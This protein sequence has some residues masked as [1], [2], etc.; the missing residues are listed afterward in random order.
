[1]LAIYCRTSKERD[2][3]S[4]TISQQRTAG[5]DFAENHK[6]EYEIYEDEGKS[7]FKISDDDR[8]PFNNRPAFTNLINDI[9]NKKIDKVWVWEH[10]RLSRN[11]FASSFIFNIF[12]RFNIKLFENQKELDLDDPQF[13]FQRQILDAVAEYERQLIIA[14]TNRGKRKQDEQGR[15]VHRELYGYE[16]DGKDDK[17]HTVWKV[18]QGEI[19]TYKYA[20]KRFNEGVSLRKIVAEVYNIN[21]IEKRMFASFACTIGRMLR[22]Y[23]YTGYQLNLEGLDIYKKFR[24][25][26]IETIQILKD[27][28]FW[29]KS[30]PYPVELITIDDWVDINEK[31]QVT[32]SRLNFTKKG[33]L[34]RASKDMATGLLKCADCGGRFYYREQKKIYVRS[35]WNKIYTSYFHIAGFRDVICDQMPRSFK[36]EQINEIF[37]LFYFFFLLVFDDTNEQIKELQENIKLKQVVSEKRIKTLEKEILNLEKQ[38][39]K[40]NRLIEKAEDEDAMTIVKFIHKTEEKHEAKTIEL[41]KLKIEFH[42]LSE[43]FNDSILE[44]TYYDVKERILKWFKELNIE[45]QRNELIKLIKQCLVYGPYILIDAGKVVFLFDTTRKY[46]FENYLL[47]NLD[48]DKV[49][50]EYFINGELSYTSKVKDENVHYGIFDVNL[51]RDKRVFAQTQAYLL[52]RLKVNFDLTEKSNLISFAYRW[53]FKIFGKMKLEDEQPDD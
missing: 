45:Q 41:S 53:A 35:G 31:L 48:K 42:N 9:R 1:M 5:I 22:K 16:K 13:K 49:Y 17:G 38:T 27:K 32:G 19:E 7:G 12:A 33:R 28:K 10:S 21:K 24:R 50:K 26:E 47:E 29:I 23:Q 40:Y 34:L 11:Q 14:R 36:I 44:M 4:S 18:N 25:Y 6:F 8:D 39:A 51:K 2:I 52:Q 15:R 30:I 43:K 37:K 46:E 3:D 20:L